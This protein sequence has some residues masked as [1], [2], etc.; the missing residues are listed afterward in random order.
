MAPGPEIG[1]AG[2]QVRVSF[3]VP[4][5]HGPWSGVG[6]SPRPHGSQGTGNLRQWGR[7]RG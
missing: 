4:H 6:T 1:P 3:A 2:P 5:S 7:P